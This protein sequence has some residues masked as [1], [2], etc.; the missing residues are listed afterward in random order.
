LARKKTSDKR[1]FV[2]GKGRSL[3]A[4]SSGLLADLRDL[5]RQARDGVAR[6]VNA[7][8]TM[9]YW[10]VG[11][12]IRTEVLKKKRADYGEQ[13]VSAVGR[14]LSLEFGRG[15]SEKSLRHMIR[16]AEVYPEDQIVSALRRQLS[17]THAP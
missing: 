14:Q 15:F 4:M 1:P 6:A 12:R 13:I 10:Q 2:R 11:Q 17:W 3:L 9:L 5:I 8:L 16:F 7:A